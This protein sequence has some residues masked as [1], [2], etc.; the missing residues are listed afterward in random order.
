MHKYFASK[1]YP[2][3]SGCCRG[4]GV[5]GLISGHAYSLLDVKELKDSNGQTAHTLVKMR[6]P[7]NSEHYNGPWNDNDSRWTDDYKR[8]VDLKQTNDGIFWMEYDT[9][10]SKWY[11]TGVALYDEWKKYELKNLKLPAKDGYRIFRFK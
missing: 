10:I 2:M 7:W 3:T 6:N 1:N 5:H 11:N 8:Q 4:G 9:Y